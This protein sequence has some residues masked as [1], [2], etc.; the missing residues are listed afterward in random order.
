LSLVPS[1]VLQDQQLMPEREDLDVLLS[2]AHRQ[3]PQQRDGLGRGEVGQS[4]QHG[5]S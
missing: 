5:S 3:E 1:L 4:Q 2:V